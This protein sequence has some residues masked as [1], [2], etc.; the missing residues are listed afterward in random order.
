MTRSVKDQP[1]RTF[2]KRAAG[3]VD[4]HLD[5]VPVDVDT[6]LSATHG[7]GNWEGG[8]GLSA[9]DVRDAMK[10]APTAG[11]PAAGSVDLH[12][13]DIEADTQDIQARLPAG[14]VG[15][16]M[17][18]DVGAISGD[19]TAADNLEAALDGTGGVTIDADLD[20]SVASVT[21]SVGSVAADR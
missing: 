4:E 20:G 19:S 2:V 14:L 1:A 3:S 18:S 5:D 8:G 6:Q 16:R 9:Q 21:G 10:L 11:A 17:D 7:A 15:G 12:L 13:D